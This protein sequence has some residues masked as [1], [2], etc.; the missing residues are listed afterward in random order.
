MESQV[1]FASLESEL[2][3]LGMDSKH[4][5]QESAAF[6]LKVKED[7]QFA[8]FLSRADQ[9]AIHKTAERL[10][11]RY[12]VRSNSTAQPQGAPAAGTAP[13]YTVDDIRTSDPV[14]D[15]PTVERPI[16]ESVR[17]ASGQ[18][19]TSHA[20]SYVNRLA[21]DL[22]ERFDANPSSRWILALLIPLLCIGFLLVIGAFLVLFA[23]T[24][25]LIIL[26]FA[27]TCG[28][29]VAGTAGTL[30]GAIYGIIKV[31]TGGAAIGWY[32]IGLAIVILGM[33]IFTGIVFYNCS[34]RFL[35]LL[36]KWI[37]SLMKRFIRRISDDVKT[38]KEAIS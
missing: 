31:F 37:G 17:E 7:E 21:A 9:T 25:L 19:E 33:T 10:Y 34:V 35:P 2:T 5:H 24:L 8:A 11:A 38:V 26:C 14:G 28:V 29:C 16:A 22:R 4:A 13:I 32:E 1:F 23:F 20:S 12:I 30:A 3:S 6:Y 27:L 36:L 18:R 15:A